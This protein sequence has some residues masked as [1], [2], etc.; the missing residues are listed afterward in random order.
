MK[1][2]VFQGD[3]ITDADR[4]RNNDDYR[5]NGYPTMVAGDLGYKYP[6]QFRFLNRGV[7]GDRIVDVN[8]RIKRDLINLKPDYLSILIGIN[9]VWHELG[10]NRNG[11]ANPKYYR[12][13]CEI[14]EEVLTMCPGVKIFILE[15]FVL[16]AAATE[17]E[18]GVFQSETALRAASARAVAEKYG[19]T[20]VPLQ[21]KFDAM[22]EKAEPSYWLLDGVHPSAMGHQLI[23][24]ALCEAYEATS[25]ES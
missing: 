11:V 8:A 14:I 24:D 10:G 2:F 7:S 21:E 19:L 20:F 4:S 22:C 17:N 1:T 16:K 6:G 13:Y 25:R 9:D 12:T 5:G 23:A 18:W 3:S 15:P